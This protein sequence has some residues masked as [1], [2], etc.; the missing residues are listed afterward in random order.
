RH[1][2]RGGRGVLAH[3]TLAGVAR[4]GLRGGTRSRAHRRRGAHRGAADRGTQAARVPARRGMVC[5]ARVRVRRARADPALA[6]RRGHRAVLRAVDEAR[7]R[8]SRARRRHGQ[9]LPRRRDGRALRRGPRRRDRRVGRR[10]RDRGPQRRAARRRRAHPVPRGGPFPR[11]AGPVPRYHVESSVRAAARARGAAARVRSRAR[12]RAPRRR[13]GARAD[14]AAAPRGRIPA[15][16]GRRADRR[17][18]GRG[19]GARGAPPAPA[20]HVARARA[21]RGGRFRRDRRAA[22][23]AFRRAD[24]GSLKLMAGDTFGRL[25]T[26]TTFGESHGP[27]LGCIVDGCPPGLELSEQDIQKELDRRRPGKSRF[28]TQRREPDTVKILSGVFQG[29]TTGTAIGLLIENVDQRT[30]DYDK[31]K[32]RFRP[33]HAD[34]TYHK[35]YG[36]RDYRGGGRASARETAMRVAAGAIARKYLRERLGIEIRGYLAALGPIELEPVDLDAVDDN[37]F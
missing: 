17:G 23:R 5:R 16:P 2:Q 13:D 31:I 1:G 30:R 32:D 9:R 28:V 11:Y 8:G 18:R 21:R 26:V 25:F 27:A 33:G 15:G 20:A 35:K 36:I 12:P 7:G 34:Y 14:R 24:S 22:R 6:A 37:P 19:R 4:R 3:P 10:A 29:V